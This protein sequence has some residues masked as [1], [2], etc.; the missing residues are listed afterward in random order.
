MDIPMQKFVS[1]SCQKAGGE[2]V[3]CNII[4]LVYSNFRGVNMIFMNCKF[5]SFTITE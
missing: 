2:R 4:T 5:K 3:D 1:H